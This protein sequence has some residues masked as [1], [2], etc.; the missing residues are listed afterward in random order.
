MDYGYVDGFIASSL[1]LF[2]GLI[3]KLEKNQS[4]MIFYN[5]VQY[6]IARR[7]KTEHFVAGRRSLR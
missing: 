6:I 1:S 2:N 7:C 4:S 5:E 3:V